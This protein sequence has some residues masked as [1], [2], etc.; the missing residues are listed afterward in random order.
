MRGRTL[1]VL[2]VVVG[3]GAA[4]A[5]QQAVDDGP[6]PERLTLADLAFGQEDYNGRRVRT[7]GVVQRFGPEDGA[8]HLH[9]V[10]ADQADN[11]V[12]LVGGDPARYVGRAVE[13]VGRFRLTESAGRTIDV[14]RIVTD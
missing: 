1:A 7:G 2:V 4:V 10:I 14:E 13:V 11:R 8:L 6:R 9:Y 3:V 5:W 12:K